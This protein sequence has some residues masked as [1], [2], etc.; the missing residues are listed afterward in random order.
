MLLEILHVKNLCIVVVMCLLVDSWKWNI[1]ENENL[2]LEYIKK[3]QKNQSESTFVTD[4]HALKLQNNPK[5]NTQ[6]Y[7]LN[8]K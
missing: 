6:K 3:I 7:K 8:A 1:M 2:M 5:W 4:D